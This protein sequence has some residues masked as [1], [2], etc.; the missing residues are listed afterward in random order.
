MTVHFSLRKLK[1]YLINTFA[2]VIVTT[3]VL[4]VA[5][6]T[7]DNIMPV[8]IE[9]WGLILNSD[10]MRETVTNSAAL[11]T[12]ICLEILLITGSIFFAYWVRLESKLLK[13]ITNPSDTP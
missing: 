10:S 13:D 7:L 4:V 1:D 12:T 2:L 9:R 6:I 3:L 8:I 11:A 5:A